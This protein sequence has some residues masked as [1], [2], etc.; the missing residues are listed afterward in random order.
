MTKAGATAK[1]KRYAE[2]MENMT[3]ITDGISYEV[4]HSEYLEE[5][6]EDGW[7]KVVS[8][9]YDMGKVVKA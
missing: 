1:A 9:E 6:I 8:Y 3:V 5:Y 4:I 2:R 7:Q